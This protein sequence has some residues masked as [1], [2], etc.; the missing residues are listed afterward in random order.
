MK[1]YFKIA[2]RN[3]IKNKIYS[4]INIAGLAAGSFQATR[5]AMANPAKSLRTE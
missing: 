1:Y 4:V 3:L 2:W 5:A